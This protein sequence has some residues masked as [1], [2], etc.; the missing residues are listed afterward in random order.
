MRR[1][2]R[3]KELRDREKE[4]TAA[5]WAQ[6]EAEAKLGSGAAAPARACGPARVPPTARAPR[7]QRP[8]PPQPLP[9]PPRA[10]PRA[11]R[12]PGPGGR[13]AGAL[14]A[15]GAAVRPESLCARRAQRLLACLCA[16]PAARP[17]PTPPNP[18][19][20][21]RRVRGRGEPSFF[22]GL[23][24]WLPFQLDFPPPFP[25]VPGARFSAPFCLTRT[26]SAPQLGPNRGSPAKATSSAHCARQEWCPY[27]S[28]TVARQ[29]QPQLSFQSPVRRTQLR[30]LR[31]WLY[32]PSPCSRPLPM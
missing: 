10:P 19:S 8:P 13:G 25:H 11:R 31:T 6:G 1:G 14:G 3:V 30:G 24:S 22:P 26:P 4:G 23:G 29:H 21:N 20:L 12:W 15:A 9:P 32:S 18:R 16:S 7:V 27:H 2:E 28:V 17:L 5:G